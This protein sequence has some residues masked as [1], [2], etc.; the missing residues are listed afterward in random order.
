MMGQNG[1]NLSQVVK[2]KRPE[3]SKFELIIRRVGNFIAHTQVVSEW[4]EGARH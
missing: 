1:Y 4:G 3:N 2:V